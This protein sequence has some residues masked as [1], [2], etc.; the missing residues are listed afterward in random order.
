MAAEGLWEEP[1]KEG[2]CL[3]CRFIGLTFM[4]GPAP[5]VR[6]PGGLFGR[7]EASPGCWLDAE[8]F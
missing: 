1:L 3:G 5:S 2:T 4:L 7:N 8:G 6:P